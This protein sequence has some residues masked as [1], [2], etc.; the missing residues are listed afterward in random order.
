MNSRIA[1]VCGDRDRLRQVALHLL[2]HAVRSLGDQPRPRVEIG[3]QE[4]NNAPVFFFRDNG[5]GIESQY[6]EKIFGLFERLDPD[7][8]GST[9]VGLA[10][11]KRIVEI[12]D[13]EVWVESEG[14][15][16]GSSFFLSLPV[17]R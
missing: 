9:G 3:V 14:L 5:I 17:A 6:Q 2:S 11:V 7:D 16:K 8:L 10:L 15:G 12:H 1:S 13:G 4:R